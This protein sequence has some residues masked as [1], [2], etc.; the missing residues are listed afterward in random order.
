MA[1][2]KI[3]N[4]LKKEQMKT[5]QESLHVRRKNEVEITLKVLFSLP[6]LLEALI[7]DLFFI[8]SSRAR[9]YSDASCYF[10]EDFLNFQAGCII[11]ATKNL[12]YCEVGTTKEVSGWCL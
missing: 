7:H 3:L 1:K 6:E 10:P 8:T 9:N 5:T 2:N 4:D 11:L 12:S